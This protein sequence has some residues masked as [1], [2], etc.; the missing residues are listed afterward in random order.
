[1]SPFEQNLTG[2]ANGALGIS[3]SQLEA[4]GPQSRKDRPVTVLSAGRIGLSPFI[5]GDRA[6]EQTWFEMHEEL[7]ALSSRGSRIV[8]DA[9]HN[10]PIEAPRQVVAAIDH[11]VAAV[12]EG[13]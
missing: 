12:R 5:D 11:V 2:L 4:A 10:L 3:V 9:G 13:S 6:R 7:A 1:M 8:V